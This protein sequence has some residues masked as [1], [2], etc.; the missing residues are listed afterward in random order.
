MPWSPNR[1]A[2]VQILHARVL[3]LLI[4][5]TLLASFEVGRYLSQNFEDVGLQK[6][7]IDYFLR[8]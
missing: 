7:K 6:G 5:A 4:D 8:E 3:H 2:S 1:V